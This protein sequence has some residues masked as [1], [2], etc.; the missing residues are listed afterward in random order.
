MKIQGSVE[1]IYGLTIVFLIVTVFFLMGKGSSLI[2]GH[3]TLQETRFDP[4]KLGKAIGGCFFVLTGFLGVTS[5]LW[6]YLPVWYGYL[7]FM[8]IGMD[9]LAVIMICHA[10]IIFRK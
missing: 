4:K 8:V 2:V 9:M 5:I 7:S 6:N 3:N 1:V 10:N